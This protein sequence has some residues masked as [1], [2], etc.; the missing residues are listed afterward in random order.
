MTTLMP[1]QAPTQILLPCRNRK[2]SDHQEDTQLPRNPRSFP[3]ENAVRNKHQP[4]YGRNGT[5]DLKRSDPPLMD[6][7][8]LVEILK[9]LLVEIESGHDLVFW[10]T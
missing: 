2:E 8:N 4:R 9:T 7:D 10:V 1:F 5:S 3:C 6:D